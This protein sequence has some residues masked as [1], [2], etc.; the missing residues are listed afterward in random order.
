MKKFRQNSREDIFLLQQC[1]TLLYNTSL[2]K[3][4]TTSFDK[5][6]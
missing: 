5:S 2:K 1:L 3:I 4:D 6:S